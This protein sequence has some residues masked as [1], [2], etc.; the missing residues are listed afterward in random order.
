MTKTQHPRRI[1]RS[2]VAL[3]TGIFAGVILTV[4]T[5]IV[6][7]VTGVFPPWGQPTGDALL[8]LATAYRVPFDIAGEL[9]R[10]TARAGSAHATR[11]GKRRCGCC[12]W[13]RGSGHDMGQEG[14]AHIGIHLL[15][16]HLR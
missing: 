7:H 8:P 14:L 10:G 9:R 1:G 3:L 15:S 2:I 11:F 5:D 4:V 16:S 13:H 6:L 12:R